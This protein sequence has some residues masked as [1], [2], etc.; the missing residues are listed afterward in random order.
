M[1][2]NKGESNLADLDQLR[3]NVTNSVQE[4]LVAAGSADPDDVVAAMVISLRLAS[5]HHDN[6]MYRAT[7]IAGPYS[8]Y[9][10][11]GGLAA[12]HFGGK[13]LEGMS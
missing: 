10:G 2:T 3:Q 4:Y 13:L 11:L 7:G 8:E 1:L 12:G 9:S 6:E 5:P